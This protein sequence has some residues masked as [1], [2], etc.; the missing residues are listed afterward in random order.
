[1]PN[2]VDRNV[3]TLLVAVVVLAGCASPQFA[4][5]PTAPDGLLDQIAPYESEI[6]L[7]STSGDTAALALPGP[8][9]IAINIV[10]HE[11]ATADLVLTG[12]GLCTS[13]KLTRGTMAT[14]GDNT[15][16]WSGRYVKDW[17]GCGIVD[18]EAVVAWQMTAGYLKGT[19]HVFIQPLPRAA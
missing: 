8:S 12:P 4:T 19:A 10:V 6:A 14:A 17:V 9:H 3:A 15:V 5:Q 11:A 1:M 13:D 18:G 16:Q 7:D 2:T